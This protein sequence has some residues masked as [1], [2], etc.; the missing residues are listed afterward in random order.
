L[1][2]NKLF[3]SLETFPERCH[4]IGV[5]ALGK[6]QRLIT[7]LR[8]MGYTQPIYLHG[9]L[10]RLCDFYQ[11]KGIELGELKLASTLD[12]Y[13]S[14]GTI[15][16]CPPSALH[17]KWARRFANVVV[18]MAS[19]WMQIR[20]RAKQKGVEL[21]LIISDHADWPEL[22]QTLREV[23]PKEVWVT[24]GREEALVFYAQQ[25]GYKAEA[26]NLLGYEEQGD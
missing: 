2:I 21:P 1:E 15:V 23:N 20:A 25:Q 14:K 7:S 3:S 11:A 6:C 19:G 5:Y 12:F 17:D 24:H 16:L 8:K 26:L 13:T 10:K 18:S 9:A 22:T 4:L